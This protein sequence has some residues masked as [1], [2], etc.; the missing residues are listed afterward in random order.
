MPPVSALLFLVGLMTLVIGAELLVRGSSRLA[1]T[2]GISPLVAGLT[3]VAFGTSAPELAV[4]AGSALAGTPELSVGNVVGSNI[5]NVLFT[6][7]VCALITPLSVHAQ[8]IRQEAPIMIGASALLLVQ[9]LDGEID[10]AEASL[11]LV[12]LVAYTVYLVRRSRFERREILDE[13]AESSPSGHWDRHWSVQVLLVAVGLVLLVVGANMLVRAASDF[14]KALGISEAVIGLT[15]VAAGTSFPELAAS[16]MA[17]FRGERDIAIG[18]VV[19]SNIFN[20]LGCVGVTGWVAQGGL[21]ISS[22]ILAF[23]LWVMLAVAVACVPVFVTG[24]EIARWEGGLFL[25]YYAS[26]TAY[27]VLVATGSQWLPSARGA[28]LSFILPL[29]IVTL[30]VSFVRLSKTGDDANAAP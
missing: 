11:L 4:S 22:D 30:V 27:L 23:D 5:F 13:Y 16:I 19:G 25:V 20:I 1:L 15:V 28:M 21:P 9:S 3:I 17:A 6:L 14:G 10:G 8:I 29:T 12:S 18:N 2:L 7:G 26:Y 24:R